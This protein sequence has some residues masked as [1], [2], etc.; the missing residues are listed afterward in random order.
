[1]SIRT[2]VV[3][4]AALAMFAGVPATAALASTAGGNPTPSPSC[5]DTVNPVGE[6]SGP[7]TPA[8]GYNPCPSPTQ[9]VPAPCPLIVRGVP[10][11]LVPGADI[12]GC[13]RGIRQEDFWLDINT[14]N[15]RG[16][17]LATGPVFF[18]VGRD[19]TVSPTLD[20][21][22]QFFNSVNVFHPALGGAS[23]DRATCTITLDQNDLT[24]RFIRGTGFY[25]NALGAGLYD[26][27]GEF[28]FP[29][30]NFACTLPVGLTAAQ[31]AYDL[32]ANGAGLPAPL[33]FDISVNATGW[34]RV[35][36]FPITPP[37]T[38]SPSYTH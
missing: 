33:G 17:V 8:F 36:P 29:T 30:R 31:A 9:P 15:P 34:A 10:Q 21:F 2:W 13:G 5:S 24:W 23:V 22:R 4:S 27:R 16:S 3:A 26:L 7:V 1:M 38:P 25:R 28:S 11:P 14:V 37:V 32:N 6:P 19:I 20:R 12:R 18:R 35:N